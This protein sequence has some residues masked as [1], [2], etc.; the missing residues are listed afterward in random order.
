MMLNR[1]RTPIGL[2]VE[3]RA[4]HAV[5]LSRRGTVW[6]VEAATRVQ[7][8]RPEGAIGAGELSRLRKILERQGFSGR[9]I[10]LAMPHDQLLTA[11]LEL[12]PAHSGAPR[13]QI[14]RIELAA[15]HKCNPES[16]EL[17]F[18]D[19]PRTRPGGESSYAMAVGCRHTDA[20]RM[21]DSFESAGFHVRGLDVQSWA[22]AR[23]VA[24]L[25]DDVNGLAAVLKLGWASA[26]L[27]V[28]LD[29]TVIFERSLADCGLNRLRDAMM[30][31]L[32]LDGDVVDY[33]LI[34]NGL[35]DESANDAAQQELVTSVRERVSAYLAHL[36]GEIR[37]S[38]SYVTKEYDRDQIQRLIVLGSTASLPGLVEHLAE[39]CSVDASLV[40]PTHVAECQG[41]ASVGCESPSLTAALGLAQY[42]KGQ[43]R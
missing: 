11:V 37:L 23:A 32:G 30:N 38:F 7:R 6:R 8:T 40:A 17:E 1:G 36:A 4:I 27:V 26:S 33:L 31:D 21:L 34:D 41:S 19:L 12:P 10:V 24:P 29:E 18:W 28:I 14:S 15:A 42:P 13:D 5:Q 22:V 2:D 3:D 39:G 16:I 35:D 20:D 25:L 9:D 43:D